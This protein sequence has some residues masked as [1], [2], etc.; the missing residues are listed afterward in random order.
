MDRTPDP[1]TTVRIVERARRD[2]RAI[3]PQVI[4]ELVCCW[5]DSPDG[6][7]VV[8]R[9]GAVVVACGD[10]GKG[11]KYSAA[12][13]DALADLAEGRARAPEV[14]TMALSRFA[15]VSRPAT[16]EPTRLGET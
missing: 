5:T 14:A 12:M 3:T 4:D 9:V 7:F 2:L 16:W 1:A 13:G 11:F 10:S 15:G 6:W 8:D